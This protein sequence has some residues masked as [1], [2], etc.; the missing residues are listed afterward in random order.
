MNGHS[1]KLVTIVAE[2]VIRERLVNDIKEMGAKGYTLT[3]V[4][5]EG[6]RGVRASEFEGKNVKIETIV[7]DAVAT[8]IVDHVA[9]G[10]F[11][12]YAVIV[13]VQDAVVV[14]GTKYV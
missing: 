6:S 13:Y 3:D 8:L 5:G 7:S 4:K 9:E 2:R 11:E 10:Y 14:R 12:N 1:L